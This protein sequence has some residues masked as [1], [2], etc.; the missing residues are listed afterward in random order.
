MQ[1]IHLTRVELA[2]GWQQGSK[3]VNCSI[4]FMHQQKGITSFLRCF[5]NTPSGVVRIEYMQRAL[6]VLIQFLFAIIRDAQ[7]PPTGFIF[8]CH[9]GVCVK[10]FNS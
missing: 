4:F 2:A 6:A 5:A 1:H 9:S 3:S 10:I 7:A 8:L